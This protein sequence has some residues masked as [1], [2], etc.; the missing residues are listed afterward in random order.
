MATNAPLPPIHMD[1]RLRE[2]DRQAFRREVAKW[3][4]QDAIQP[5]NLTHEIADLKKQLDSA[6]YE[7]QQAR[8]LALMARVE[9]DQA[10]AERNMVL[11]AY[12]AL[13]E[14]H[15]KADRAAAAAQEQTPPGALVL[16]AIG[17]HQDGGQR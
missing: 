12:V 14:M 15:V 5:L 7:E 10:I 17:K 16:A 11:R 6:R 2:K 3:C 4:A 1:E 13:L 9:R 8:K